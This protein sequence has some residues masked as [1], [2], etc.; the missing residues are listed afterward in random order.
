M[1]NAEPKDPNASRVAEPDASRVKEPNASH[2][3]EPNVTLQQDN[4]V[5]DRSAWWVVSNL[6]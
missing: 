6:S 5:E 4:E 2:V 3:A 1:P